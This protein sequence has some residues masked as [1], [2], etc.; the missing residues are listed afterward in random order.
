MVTSLSEP[1]PPPQ[2]I[3]DKLSWY[4]VPDTVKQL[5]VQASA[6]WDQP[7]LANEYMQEAL[8]RA[9]DHPDV[10]VSAYR[11]Y[12]YTQNNT[13]ALQMANRVLT[14]V[15]QTE[16]LPTDWTQ[17]KPVLSDRRDDPKIRLYI[18]AYAASGLIQAR[19]GAVEAAK[20][21]STRVSELEHR[22]EF[23]GNVVRD[24]LEHP[25]DEDES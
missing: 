12:F 5:L 2:P 22:N 13:Q 1:Q 17:L 18:N 20:E 7:E 6:Y 24:I 19:L 11:Y 4:Q 15:R 25:D 16:A 8:E 9:G 23:G 21:I 10:L 3:R 14:T